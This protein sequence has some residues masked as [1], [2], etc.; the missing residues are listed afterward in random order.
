[1]INRLQIKQNQKKKKS[2]KHKEYTKNYRAI[3]IN[4]KSN[5]YMVEAK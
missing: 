3:Y 1:M 2:R 4:K 5:P